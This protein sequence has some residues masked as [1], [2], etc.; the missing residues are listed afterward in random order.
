VVGD[1]GEGVEELR[2]GLQEGE[3][4]VGVRE[5]IEGLA[6][7]RTMESKVVPLRTSL[8]LSGRT[9]RHRRILLCQSGRLERHQP[10]RMFQ[11]LQHL[12]LPL[13]AQNHLLLSLMMT[14]TWTCIRQSARDLKERESRS[15]LSSDTTVSL[16][17]PTSDYLLRLL[18]YCGLGRR[19]TP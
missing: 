13:L 10:P 15:A 18:V 14:M 11:Q 19:F 17:L 6:R 12:T 8:Y 2:E 9:R 16:L 4:K 3:A 7:L 5:E 1:E